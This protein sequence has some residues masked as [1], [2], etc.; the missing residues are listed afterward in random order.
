MKFSALADCKSKRPP[1][2]MLIAFDLTNLC[3]FGRRSFF[4]VNLFH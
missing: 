3:L 4:S 2:K 1:G